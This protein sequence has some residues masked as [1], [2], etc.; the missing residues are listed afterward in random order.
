ME[1]WNWTK[2]K[3]KQ[4]WLSLGHFH[5]LECSKAGKV[6]FLP[7]LEFSVMTSEPQPVSE[8][9]ACNINGNLPNKLYILSEISPFLKTEDS[10]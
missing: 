8:Q 6:F 9:L 2:K 5:Y 10:L 7:I 3:K 1:G 4:T